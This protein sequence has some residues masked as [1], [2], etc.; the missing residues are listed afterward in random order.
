M[1]TFPGFW[2]WPLS[3]I[4][5]VTKLAKICRQT[6]WRGGRGP[7]EYRSHVSG[8]GPGSMESPF[9]EVRTLAGPGLGVGLGLYIFEI[10]LSVHVSG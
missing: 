4:N 3:R 9:S 7:R 5:F 1:V 6:P 10:L 8:C 2:Q